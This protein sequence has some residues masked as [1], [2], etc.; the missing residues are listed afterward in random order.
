M[1]REELRQACLER[2]VACALEHPCGHQ[3]KLC[4]EYRDTLAEE[5]VLRGLVI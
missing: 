3:G 1:T 4:L 2:L 5:P